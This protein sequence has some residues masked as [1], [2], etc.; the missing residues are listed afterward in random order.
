M[1]VDAAVLE[2]LDRRQAGLDRGRVPVERPAEVDVALRVGVEPLHVH[3]TPADRG[4]RKAVG[5]RL[6]HRRE[7]G[8]H[9]G[10]RLDSA[11][12]VPE[13]GDDLVEDEQRARLVA[14]AAQARQ[15]PIVRQE[16]GRVVRE[17]LDD[18]RGDVIAMP[19]ERLPHVV[20]VVE[21]AD[22]RGVDR[23]FEHPGGVRIPPAEPVRRA[24]DVPEHV[25]VKAVVTALEL[26]DLLPS[27]DTTGEPQRVIR[28]LRSATRRPHGGSRRWRAQ[29]PSGRERPTC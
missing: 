18:H 4:Q 2:L 8:H 5:D 23:R 11:D 10:N 20:E 17:R 12:V 16:A 19:L 29:R 22:E 3:A 21:A 7:V 6:A 9:A 28:R 14:Q 25:V 27:R 15:E 24:E 13:T 1:L 26:D